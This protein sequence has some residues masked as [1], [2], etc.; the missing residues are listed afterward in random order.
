MEESIDKKGLAVHQVVIVGSGASGIAAALEFT[1]SGIKPLILDVGHTQQIDIP[2]VEGNLYDYRKQHDTFDLLIGKNLQNFTN[3]FT[4]DTV[5]VKLTSPY[6]EYITHAAQTLSPIDNE[7]FY[8][9][10]SFAIGGLANAWGAGLYRYNDQDLE[11]FPIRAKDLNFYYDKLTQEIGISGDEDDLAPFFGSTKSL[12]PPIKLSYNSNRLYRNYQRKKGKFQAHG[13]FMGLPRVGVL[14]EDR[15]GHSACDYS[16]LEF[17]KELPYIYTP[18][19]TL[20]KLITTGKVD[21]KKGIFVE[22]WNESTEGIRI[23]AVTVEEN[24]PISFHCKRLVLAAGAINTAKIVLNS[25]QDYQTRLVL[26]E[27]PAMQIP[28]FLPASFGRRLDTNSFGLVQLNLVWESD[29][30]N[31]LLQGSVMETTSPMRGVFYDKFPLSARANLELIKYL[32]PS[33][34]IMQLYLPASFQSPSRLSLQKNGRLYIQ[35]KPNNIDIRK[36][37]DVFQ[38]FRMLGAWS[39]PY[40]VF[41]VPTGQA[42]HYAGTLPMREVSGMYECDV[43]GKLF[44][45]QNVYIADSST[46]P[47]LPAKNMGLTLMANAMRVAKQVASQIN[48]VG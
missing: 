15:N 41:R 32:L 24:H 17:W 39:F 43:N 10:Q 46:F 30:F 5:P 13:F 36:M 26:L 8:V 1:E 42:I 23:N 29:T 7:G 28:I 19:M 48:N 35:G 6:A 27:N 16:N 18:K 21:Y 34:L 44:G 3:L 38:F 12:L 40:L 33:M 22:G 20:E 2:Q 11:G 4:G 14:T 45:T 25:F 47:N 37:R 9:I 31:C